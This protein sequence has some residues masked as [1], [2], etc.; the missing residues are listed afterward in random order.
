MH[1]RSRITTD[2]RIPTMP[3]RGMCGGGSFRRKLLLTEEL[4]TQY[5]CNLSVLCYFTISMP[6][7]YMPINSSSTVER[8]AFIVPVFQSRDLA[9]RYTW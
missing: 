2:P 9:R 4:Y 6:V 7:H 5:L 1:G 8:T 3:G